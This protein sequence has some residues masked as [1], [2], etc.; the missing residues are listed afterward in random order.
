VSARDL[1]KAYLHLIRSY[2]PEHSPDE[3][4][5]IRDAYE[6]VLPY[7]RG[8]DSTR[9]RPSSDDEAEPDPIPGSPPIESSWNITRVAERPEA[10]P[11]PWNL[12]CRG[13]PEAA[14]RALVEQ[15]D[16]GL[17]REDAYLQLYWLLAILPALD[18]ARTPVD[19]LIRGLGIGDFEAGRLRELLRREM[20]ADPSLPLGDR[21]AGFL[22][23]RT[24]GL[25]TLDIVE[26][27]W[28]AARKA[29]RWSLILADVNTLRSW[30]PEV[31]EA[32]WAR[33]LLA[34]SSNLA[35]AEKPDSDHA[36]AFAREV[37]G[38]GHRSQDH[39]D[40][41][42]QLEYVQV[43]KSG[44]DRLGGR[45]GAFGGIFQL[46][47]ISWDEQGPEFR[48]R[49]RSYVD[50]IAQDPTASLDCLD[51]IHAQAP[52][53]LGRLSTLLGLDYEEFRFL[54]SGA[55]AE[56]APSID[57]FLDSNG[58]DDYPALRPRLLRF[59]LREAASP[60]LVARTMAER[61]E[62]ILTGKGPLSHAIVEDWPLRHVYR[63]C[64]LAWQ[65]PD[66]S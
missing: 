49:F 36:S 46:L 53:V 10:T 26:A 20:A 38:L 17:A 40:E 28:R 18:A 54:G 64:E 2:K 1:R 27:R 39:G 3:F 60:G 37:E 51:Q 55:Y 43:V 34:A 8:L 47:A 59:C 5:R 9:G 19:W 35:W 62:F 15:Q 7:T 4:R 22:R 58:W 21:L 13:E 63:A 52:A 65:G 33:V 61:P 24:P 11:D 57:R 31:D 56:M 23:N 30:M 12:A 44:L 45:S 16:R 48:S 32:A 66:P 29:R 50:Q 41:L 25:L 42:Y 14:Y 6:S